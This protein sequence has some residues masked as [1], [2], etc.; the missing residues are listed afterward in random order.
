MGELFGFSITIKKQSD[1]NKGYSRSDGRWYTN[2]RAYFGQYLDME[3]LWQ[4]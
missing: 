4:N 1:Q 3:V 2:Y